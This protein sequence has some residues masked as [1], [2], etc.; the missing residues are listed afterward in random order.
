MGREIDRLDALLGEEIGNGLGAHIPGRLVVNEDVVLAFKGKEVC[1][2]NAR[3]K[4]ASH[5]ERDP[6][7]MSRV[8]NQRRHTDLTKTVANIDMS[9]RLLETRGV[10]G[11]GRV[12]LE[13]VEP[14]QGLYACIGA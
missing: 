8:K 3:S 6:L 5:R 7:I 10:P 13:F 1:A 11:R 12:S 4:R 14:G 2:G 9:E